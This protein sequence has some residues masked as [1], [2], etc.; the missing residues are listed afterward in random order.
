LEGES[1]I[2]IVDELPLALK[3]RAGFEIDDIPVMIQELTVYFNILAKTGV[4]FEEGSENILQEIKELK[5]I[6]LKAVLLVIKMNKDV[7]GIGKKEDD[8]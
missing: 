7:A 3:T 2:T 8:F 6:V 4:A 1:H 5:E